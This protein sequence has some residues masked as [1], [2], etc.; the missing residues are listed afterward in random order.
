LVDGTVLR[1]RL[2]FA[3]EELLAYRKTKAAGK[4]ASAFE[5]Y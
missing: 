5:L 2:S 4:M 3:A 1:I